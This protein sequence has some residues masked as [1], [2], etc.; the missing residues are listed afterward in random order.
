ML[1]ASPDATERS[2]RLK[3]VSLMLYLLF[4]EGWSASS[5]EV[6]IKEPLCDEAIRL[7]RLL[8]NLFPGMGELMG[9]LSL[10]LFQHSRTK[11]RLDGNGNRV[12]LDDQDRNLWDRPVI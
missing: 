11:A 4:N 7:T 5:G 2:R 10:F 1:F 6:Q 12:V 8:L 3:T 9:L